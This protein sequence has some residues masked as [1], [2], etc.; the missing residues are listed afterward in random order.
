MTPDTK[1]RLFGLFGLGAF[2]VWLT[3]GLGS[4][5]YMCLSSSHWPKAQAIVTTSEVSTGTSNVGRWWQPDLRYQYQVGGRNYQSTAVRFLM[6]LFYHPE[7]ARAIQAQYPQNSATM[8]AYDPG[9]PAHSVLQPG[10]PAG[11]W[12]QALIPL[13][14][15]TLIGYIAYEI[16][17]PHRRVLLNHSPEPAEAEE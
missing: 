9:N 11:M 16:R 7:E 4:N 12:S 14:F 2:A 6:P 10:V 13:F 15:W 3:L 5:F 17:H 8:A 1:T